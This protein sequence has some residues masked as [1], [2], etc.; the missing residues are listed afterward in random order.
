MESNPLK[1]FAFFV[2]AFILLYVWNANSSLPKWGIIPFGL[3][4]AICVIYG[5]RS[6]RGGGNKTTLVGKRKK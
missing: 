6:W 5:I 2:A 1:A 4:V 3:A